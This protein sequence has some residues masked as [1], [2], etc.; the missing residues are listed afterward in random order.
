[1]NKLVKGSIAGAAGIALLLGGAG[2]F[3]LWNDSITS[4]AGAVSSGELKIANSAT[5]GG[6]WI[7]VSTSGIQNGT[8]LPT[9]GTSPNIVV[10]PKIVPGDKWRFTRQIVL[11]TT[12]KNLLADLSFDASSVTVAPTAFPAGELSYKLTATPVVVTTP[13]ATSATVV[14]TAVGSGIYRVTPGSA[15]TTTVNLTVDVEFKDVV[16][17]NLSSG[18]GLTINV[19]A[20]KFNLTQ[21]RV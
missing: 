4:N 5:P 10:T 8:A 6:S 15:A 17:G 14:E 19:S 18:Q 21:V 9:T 12:G 3:A 16:A 20:L 11:T 7:D 13:G 1:M 2:T